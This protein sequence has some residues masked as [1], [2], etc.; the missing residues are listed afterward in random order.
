MISVRI[1]VDENGANQGNLIL[2]LRVCFV[3][4]WLVFIYEK[5]VRISFRGAYHVSY[6]LSLSLPP[7]WIVSRPTCEEQAVICNYVIFGNT[8]RWLAKLIVNMQWTDNS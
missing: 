5:I 7:Y 2:E 1:L 6:S 4:A 8:S 3:V